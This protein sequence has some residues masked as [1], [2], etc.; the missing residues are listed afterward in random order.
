MRNTQKEF[1]KSHL[2]LCVRPLKLYILFQSEDVDT[3]AHKVTWQTSAAF[4]VP[5]KGSKLPV[6]LFCYR[7]IHTCTHM[8]SKSL[9]RM[10]GNRQKQIIVID[11]C[12]E[13]D[14]W[15]CVFTCVPEQRMVTKSSVQKILILSSR[16]AMS[17][18]QG[19]F[20]IVSPISNLP[21]LEHTHT[22]IHTEP[23]FTFNNITIRKWWTAH[24]T[25]EL[26]E[27]RDKSNL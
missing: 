13:M 2:L 25:R 7:H 6:F 11:R 8:P 15:V 16:E 22:H 1:V 12:L 23:I 3:W 21:S 4:W 26:A 9:A 27:K 24:Q 18:I 14:L 10:T 17:L 19:Q 5:V 20:R